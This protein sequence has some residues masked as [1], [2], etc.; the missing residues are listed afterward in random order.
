MQKNVRPDPLREVLARFPESR[1]RIR[2]L[3]Q[4]DEQF[5]EL[6][7]DY[8]QCQAALQRFREQDADRGDRIEQYTELRVS[9]EQELVGKISGPAER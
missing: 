5:R 1:D 3:F 2:E 8:G 4:A 9:I 7:T 6:C